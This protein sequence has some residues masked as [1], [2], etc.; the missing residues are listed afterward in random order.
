VGAA[1][2]RDAGDE[3]K[4]RVATELMT[5][6]S[7]LRR[8]FDANTLASLH[9]N[10]ARL[11]RALG[12]ADEQKALHDSIMRVDTFTCAGNRLQAGEGE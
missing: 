2:F 9:P 12:D 11:N 4:A 1:R 7:R 6:G 8:V 5:D 3:V 10:I